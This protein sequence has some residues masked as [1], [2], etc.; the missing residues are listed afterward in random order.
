V[1][2]G[3]PPERDRLDEPPA[4]QSGPAQAADSATYELARLSAQ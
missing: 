2:S 4:E 3:A 1:T